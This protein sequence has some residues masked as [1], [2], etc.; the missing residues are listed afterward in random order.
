MTNSHERDLIDLVEQFF[1]AYN[2]MDLDAFRALLT[3]D[4]KWGHHNRFQG[5]GADGLVQSI[6][7][8]QAKLPDRRFGNITNWAINGNRVYTEHDW[9]ATP[10]E[11]DPSWGWVA[12]E[13]TAMD[14]CSIF[15][16]DGGRVKE[17]AD[18]G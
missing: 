5:E 13:P 4:I 10:T 18:Y 14:A 8:I 11:S 1:T 7:D 2:E 15:V 17:W 6:R 9:Q 3:D 12:G 16:F